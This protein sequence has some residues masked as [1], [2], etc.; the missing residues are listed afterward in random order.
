MQKKIQLSALLIVLACPLFS[1]HDR[2]SSEL[3][4]AEHEF[5]HWRAALLLGHTFIPAG[6]STS[7]LAIPSWGFDLE[8]WVNPKWGIGLHNDLEIQSFIVERE[9]EELLDREYPVVFTID[10]L[11][12][13]WKELVLLIGPGVELEPKENFFLVRFGV[14]YEFEFGHGWDISPT[15]FYDT[16]QDAYDTWSIALGIGK[17]F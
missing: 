3:Q 10:A 8:Y 16:R 4:Q 15:I 11:F 12:K 1:Q 2:A 5:T 14:E 17:R 6:E 7:H 13:P 9:N